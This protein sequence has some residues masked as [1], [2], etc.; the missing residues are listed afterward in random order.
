[1]VLNGKVL[2]TAILKFSDNWAEKVKAQKY[3]PTF[4]D[5]EIT[6]GLNLIQQNFEFIPW[7]GDLKEVLLRIYDTVP[8][9]VPREEVNRFLE[10]IVDWYNG[11]FVGYD[12]RVKLCSGRS[13]STHIDFMSNSNKP[14][15][16]SMSQGRF[17]CLKWKEHILFKTAYDLAIYQMMIWDLKPKTIIEIGS[18][19]GGSAIWM[20]DLIS[21][22]GLECEIISMDINPPHLQYRNVTFFKGDC[23]NI[24]SAFDANMLTELQH[25]WLVVEDA[26]VNV[27]GVLHF[28]D[29]F[30]IA[31]DYL[32]VEDS[33]EI[34]ETHAKHDIIKKFLR[35]KEDC[36]KV[37]AQYCD[38]FGH[39]MTC[40]PNSIFR[41]FK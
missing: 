35:N 7:D 11:R 32:V 9:E 2:K 20:S 1:M 4:R 41:R 23:N 3:V 24:E 15:S 14:W 27:A 28:F 39:N 22:F 29:P 36:Y 18:G 38:F 33:G 34:E 8:Q 25:P 10:Q 30:L 19:N 16:F 21:V 17:D 40:S 13:E 5:H 26:H 12:L 6:Y 31:G 37:D